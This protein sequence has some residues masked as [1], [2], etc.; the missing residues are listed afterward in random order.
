MIAA[1]TDKIDAVIK[2][3]IKFSSANEASRI[4]SMLPL[5]NQQQL[6]YLQS[7]I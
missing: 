6:P 7:L 2:C 3:C 1:G 4:L 5:Q